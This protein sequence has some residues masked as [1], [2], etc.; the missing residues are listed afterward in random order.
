MGQR[1]R[2]PGMKRETGTIG[3]DM[4]IHRFW[5]RAAPERRD[6][7]APEA[8][9]GGT[10]ARGRSAPKDTSSPVRPE[11]EPPSVTFADIAGIDEV[12]REVE[13]LVQ[14]LRAP[15]H[16]ERLGARLPRGALLVGPP[17]TG[18]T[19]LAKAVAGEAGVSFFSMSGSGL[20]GMFVGVGGPRGRGPF[21][22]GEGHAPRTI[23]IHPI[24][25]RRGHRG[26]GRR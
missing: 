20:V 4:H 25:A 8:P 2:R 5:K 3:D 17:G 10:P 9:G 15:E 24:D 13:E 12:R 19:L 6:P 18:K 7:Q 26:A 11:L 23:F 14:F 21:E 22:A 16:F 1:G